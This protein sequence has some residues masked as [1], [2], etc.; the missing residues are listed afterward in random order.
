M[1][2][3]L[4]WLISTDLFESVQNLFSRTIVIVGLKLV[5]Y[6]LNNY[7]LRRVWRCWALGKFW[8]RFQYSSLAS[9]VGL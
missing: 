1:T 7:V 3:K 4:G 8:T 9:A 2:G 6:M 5:V